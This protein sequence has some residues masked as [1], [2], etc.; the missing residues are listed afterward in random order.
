MYAI[1]LGSDWSKH[2]RLNGVDLFVFDVILDVWDEDTRHFS[3]LEAKKTEPK[4]IF[5]KNHLWGQFSV[6]ALKVFAKKVFWKFH[7]LD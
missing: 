7:A 2:G 4:H 3:V 1:E 6:F 5:C